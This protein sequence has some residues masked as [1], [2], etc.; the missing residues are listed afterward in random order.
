[1]ALSASFFQASG[2]WWSEDLFGQ[3]FSIV[4]PIQALRGLPCLGFFS[5][6][7]YIRHIEGP[8]RLGSYSVDACIR[9]LKWHFGWGSLASQSLKGTSWVGSYSVVQWVSHLIGQPLYCSVADAA[10]VAGEATVMA[11]P[12]THDSA[13]SPCF[14]ACL[15]FLHRH[16]PPQSPLSCPLSLSLHSQQQLSPWDC[17][18][19]PTLQLPVAASSRGTASLSEVHIAATWTV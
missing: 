7:H 1:M 19:I 18:I 2:S 15:A 14:H 4:L 12:P 17:S 5:V 8:S 9:Q 11:P 6:V 16:V 13:V 10:R 3:S